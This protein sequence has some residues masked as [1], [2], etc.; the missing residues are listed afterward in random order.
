MQ[1]IRK[2]HVD[3]TSAE[4]GKLVVVGTPIG[5]LG[6]LS[7]RAEAALSDADVVFA[8]D[9]RVT[10]RLLAH[11]GIQVPLERCDE[12]VIAERAPKAAER[13]AAGET[14]VFCSDAGMP[15]ISDPGQVLVRVV[16]AAG[17]PVEV[18]PGPTAVTTALATSGLDGR[19]FYFGGFLPRKAGERVR[20]LETLRA[21]PSALVFYESPHRVK[22]S[23]EAVA[24]VMPSRMVCLARE[25]T[26]L[27]EEE[28][29]GTA[30]EIIDELESRD[31]QLKGEIVLVID[32]PGHGEEGDE[33]DVGEFGAPDSTA[34]QSEV[35]ALL[36][37]G[38]KPTELAGLIAKKLG[39]SKRAVYSVMCGDDLRGADPSTVARAIMENIREK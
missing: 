38:G 39:M 28:L 15:C 25:L 5:N 13:I 14:I 1:G 33:S 2:G 3:K 35:E 32:A 20:L 24:K 9:T 18:V 29:I 34:L 37:G 7:P 17:L 23:L 4:T 22:A 6:D 16:R 27:H 11:C 36:A 8:E 10:S 12:N 26:K 30:A 19:T 21:L 31:G